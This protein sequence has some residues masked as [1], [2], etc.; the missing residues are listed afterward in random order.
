MSLDPKA[1]AALRRRQTAGFEQVAR[2]LSRLAKLRATRISDTGR[3]RN[4]V[5]HTVLPEGG[6]LW[7]IPVSAAPQAV[8]LEHGFAPHW[9]PGKYVSLWAKREGVSLQGGK[10]NPGLF[11]GGPGSTLDYADGGAQ[12]DRLFGPGGKRTLRTYLTKGQSS[13]YLDRGKVGHSIL[14]YTAQEHGRRI[15]PQ[16]FLRGFRSA[17]AGASS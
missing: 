14:Q 9:V 17:G 2:E 7:G 15:A 10:R 6:V 12:T 13:K 4:S 11:I 1:I 8:Y 3:R 5:T 16:A